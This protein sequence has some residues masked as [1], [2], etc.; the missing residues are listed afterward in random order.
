MFMFDS[1]N[2]YFGMTKVAAYVNF[3]TLFSKHRGQTRI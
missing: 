2:K 3:I 1:L